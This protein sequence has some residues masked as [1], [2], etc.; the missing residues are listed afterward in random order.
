MIL[1]KICHFTLVFTAK[2]LIFD[3]KFIP[4]SSKTST[5]ANQLRIYLFLSYFGG[6]A[7]LAELERC[8]HGLARQLEPLLT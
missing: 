6:G 5:F 1:M 7:L 3:P 4:L 8:S 2:P